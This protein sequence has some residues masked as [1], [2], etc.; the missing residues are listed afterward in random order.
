MK[1]PADEILSYARTV[2]LLLHNRIATFFLLHTSRVSIR[3]HLF[4]DV[5]NQEAGT[6]YSISSFAVD[7]STGYATAFL[8]DEEWR[9]LINRARYCK[10]KPDGIQCC[11]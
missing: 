7:R 10:E 4:C 1:F 9:V 3:K 2:I 6:L 5:K 11:H 8:N